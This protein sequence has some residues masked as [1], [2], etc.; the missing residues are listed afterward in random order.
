MTKSTPE[1][2]SMIPMSARLPAVVIV[3]GRTQIDPVV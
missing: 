2:E 3:T 1:V